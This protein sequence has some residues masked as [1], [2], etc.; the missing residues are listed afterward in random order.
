MYAG[1]PI[2]LAVFATG[3]WKKR[4]YLGFLLG[5]V[6]LVLLWLVFLPDLLSINCPGPC[7][8][9]DTGLAM[10]A[11]VSMLHVVFYVG[12]TSLMYLVIYLLID[13][14]TAVIKAAWQ[15]VVILIQMGF[16]TL[17]GVAAVVLNQEFVN[18]LTMFLGLAI[19]ELASYTW[20]VVSGII[21]LVMAAG[22]WV[23]FLFYRKTAP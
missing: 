1:L 22:V 20:L 16:L 3:V 6:P 13:P 10:L 14:S 12:T 15:K 4:I 17:L 11:G 2:S 19:L 7:Q 18:A 21:V 9:F 8:E 23:G 5:G